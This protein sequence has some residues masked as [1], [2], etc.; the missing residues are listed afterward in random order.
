M[1]GIGGVISH[2]MD[3][4]NLYNVLNYLNHRG[5][6][7]TGLFYWSGDGNYTFE[8]KVDNYYN[9]AFGHKRLSII[10]LS[11]AASQPFRSDNGK[12][13]LTYNGEVYNYLEIREDLSKDG[14]A[15]RTE[16]DT[17]VVLKAIEFWGIDVAIDKFRGMFAFSLFDTESGEVYLVRDQFGIKPLYYCNWEDKIIFSSEIQPLINLPRLNKSINPKRVWHYIRFG[18]TNYGSDTLISAI[19]QV[20]PATYIKFNVYDKR[21]SASSK[22]YWDINSIK[23]TRVP[24]NEATLRVRE[25]FL[26]NIKLHLRSD[27]PLGVALSGGL[28]SSAIV[29]S[30]KYLYPEIDLH[31]FSFISEDKEDS[32]EKWID[33][34][35]DYC[36]T[37]SHKIKTTSRDLLLDI[38]KIIDLQGEP[39]GSTSIH[40]QYKI[41]EL[42]RDTGIKVMLDGQGADEI[43]AGYI[44]FQGARL[45][46]ILTRLNFVKLKRF[47]LAQKKY[48]DRNYLDILKIG[49]GFI[50][51][52]RLRS[53]PRQIAGK[54]DEPSWL[55]KDWFK[56]RK[57]NL[58]NP[59]YQFSPINCLRKTL[60]ESVQHGLLD[61]LRFEDRNSM[62]FSIESRVPFLTTDF[63]EYLLSLPEEYLISE[64]GVTKYVFREAMRGIVPDEILDRVDKKGFNTPDLK[65]IK[66]NNDYFKRIIR[67]GAQLQLFEEKKLM[68]LYTE[69]VDSQNKYNFQV[70][71]II[72]FIKW[73]DLNK[74]EIGEEK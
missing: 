45:S 60:I 39:F 52:P 46:S 5:P 56:R 30:I 68:N 73:L 18:L 42:A 34:V 1:C 12:F 37:T 31:T 44:P 41:F 36:K 74:I 47:L 59:L 15:F 10:D 16:C 8:Y 25:L 26:N 38:D 22:L 50:I 63:V 9:V 66:E 43:L 62:H 64:D 55:N 14:V 24:F 40:S 67:S 33:I 35:N 28:D 20:P 57:V 51:P 3:N 27:V 19:K 49:L 54:S 7:N 70:W 4:F 29:C 11:D 61:L 2:K 32:E 53:L 6:D 58:S 48:S 71:R 17:E 13:W 23:K 69:N 21:L 72:N 65:W